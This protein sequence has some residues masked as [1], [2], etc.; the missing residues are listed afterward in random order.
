MNF[1]SNVLPRT[2]ISTIALLTFVAAAAFQPEPVGEVSMNTA[3]DQQIVAPLPATITKPEPPHIDAIV[4]WALNR[5]R[6]QPNVQEDLLR[7]YV[8]LTFEE[9][10]KWG[11]D[12]LLSLA[13]IAVESRFNYKANSPGGAKG[14]MQVIPF[15]HKDKITVAEAYHPTANIRAGNMV[16]RDCFAR[17][18]GN[19]RQALLCY[20]GSLGV[21]GATYDK[22]VLNTRLTLQRAIEQSV[23]PNSLKQYPK[24]RAKFNA[25]TSNK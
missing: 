5:S 7:K 2:L 6:G 1:F 22:K 4:D 16:L 14:L 20:N 24:N 10:T 19:T 25:S 17:Q 18:R 15:W 8:I 3:H 9:A 23:E 12:P 21:T 13:V 11:I